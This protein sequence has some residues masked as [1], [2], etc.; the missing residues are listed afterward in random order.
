MEVKARCPHCGRNNKLRAESTNP[1]T[2]LHCQ[3]KIPYRTMGQFWLLER[4]GAGG[5]GEVYRGY[6]PSLDREVAIK[7]LHEKASDKEGYIRFEREAR[8]TAK[9][10]HPNV[11]PVFTYGKQGDQVY[12]VSALIH[13]RELKQYI[14]DGGFPDVAQ[15]VGYAITLLETLHEVHERYET[16]HRDVKPSNIMIDERGNVFLLDFGIAASQ[17]P[18][19]PQLTRPGL[20][21]GTPF[22]MPPEQVRMKLDLVG[23]KSDQYSLAV[24]IYQMLTGRLPFESE[25]IIDIFDQILHEEPTP[26]SHYR[27]D[28]DRRLE[29]VV[30]R[31]MSKSLD[32][33][34]ADC[35][36][37]AAALRNWLDG[38]APTAVGDRTVRFE[39]ER[40]SNNTLKILAIVAAVAVVGLLALIISRGTG[41]ATSSLKNLNNQ[42]VPNDKGAYQPK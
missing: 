7:I 26:P 8:L 25:A 36:Q 30:M 10:S 9:I 13:G 3:K 18:E 12:L 22:Y 40:S 6:E 29:K 23:P 24:V 16:W 39:G 38:S 17:D 33:R 28:L 14:T 5:F 37:F 31:A 2:C 42:L 41:G 27:P 1:L 32:R 20:P 34:Y 15:A 21:M 19:L 11:A 4:L 35:Q